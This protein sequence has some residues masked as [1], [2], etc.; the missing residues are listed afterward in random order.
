[1]AL[2]RHSERSLRNKRFNSSNNIPIFLIAQ[3]TPEVTYLS[4]AGGGGGGGYAWGGGAGAG[5]YLTGNS[6]ITIGTSYTIIVGAGGVGG[7]SPT[8]ETGRQGGNSSVFSAQSS[9]GGGGGG[10]GPNSVSYPQA[11][12]PYTGNVAF[13]LFGTEIT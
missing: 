10:W 4:V 5:G 2:V 3:A 1:M 11:A 9:G 6:F 12:L 7:V 8:G 13:N